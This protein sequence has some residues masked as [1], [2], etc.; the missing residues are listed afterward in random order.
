MQSQIFIS[1]AKEDKSFAERIYIDLLTSRFTPWI[2]S[3]Q[4]LGGQSWEKAIRGAIRISSCFLA[5]LSSQ[6]VGKRG[7]V[8]REIRYALEVAEK[9][10]EGEIFV[11]PLRI[12]ECETSFEG[13][14]R[15]HRIDLF[16]SYEDGFEALLE[17]LKYVQEVKPAL[18]ITDP[19]PWGGEIAA[20]RDKG[21]GFIEYN[22]ARPELFF[23]SNEL[24]G[25]SFDELQLRDNVTFQ[26]ADGPKGAVAVN[27]QRL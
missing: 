11:V 21:F 19:R 16:P 1:Y 18:I 10:P 13:L 4:I 3:K 23:H 5:I 14:Q 7:F 25:V 6:S 17:T 26:I 22:F 9:F 27:V 12:D 20:L 2:D 15:L 24:I 8:Q